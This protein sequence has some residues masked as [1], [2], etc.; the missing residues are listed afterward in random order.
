MSRRA[1]GA[2]TL[3][4]TIIVLWFVYTTRIGLP[5]KPNVGKRPPA[6]ADVTYGESAY[7]NEG[8]ARLPDAIII[9]SKKAGTRA[10]LAWLNVHPNV[11]CYTK[12]AHFFDRDDAFARGIDYYR[13]LMPSVNS[14]QWILEKTPSYLVTPS[15]PNRIAQTMPARTKFI[16]IFREPVA[17]AISDFTQTIDKT[18][19]IVKTSKP[20]DV[21]R[22][23][24]LK[25]CPRDGS[26][27]NPRASLVA[28]GEYSRHLR[29]WLHM[30][31]RNRFLFLDAKK[32]MQDP[33]GAMRKVEAFLNLPA[34]YN[35]SRFYFNKEKGFYC[36]DPSQPGYTGHGDGC[37]GSNKGRE[38][39][40]I[41]DK[42]TKL[43]QA[44]FQPYNKELEVLTGVKF[45]WE[46]D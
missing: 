25:R 3:T 10:L 17:R 30:F 40:T 33:V 11:T 16:A 14:S 21:F 15:V 29:T 43:L 23:R 7:V 13:N 6:P 22:S 9:G 41:D 1:I 38:H 34:Y 39:V 24:V 8:G 18:P 37:L 20:S 45:S 32:F 4:S 19:K 27:V 5:K 2:V 46:Y 31:A 26:C 44:H 36:R 42:T 28:I 35:P 12:E